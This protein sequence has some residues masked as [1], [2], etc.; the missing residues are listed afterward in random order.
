LNRSIS[1]FIPSFIGQLHQINIDEISNDAYVR[2]YFKHLCSHSKY[3]L[4]IYAD[5]LERAEKATQ[6][7]RSDIALLDYGAGLGLLGIFAAVAGFGAVSINEREVS[8][9]NAAEKISSFFQLK[10]IEFIAGEITPV[11]ETESWGKPDVLVAT[12]VIEH[13]YS[14]DEFLV[15]AKKINNRLIFIFTTGSN[16]ENYW[17]VKKLQKL[18]WR[19]EHLGHQPSYEQELGGYAHESFL[20]LRKKLIAQCAPHLSTDIVFSLARDTR[21]LKKDDLLNAIQRYEKDGLWP[22]VDVD[23][24]NTCHPETGSWT[25]KIV[26][27][28]QYHAIFD[29]QKYFIKFDPG[30]Y[31]VDKKGFKS[32]IAKMA[33]AFIFIFGMKIAPFIFLTAKISTSEISNE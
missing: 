28:K 13:L 29:K 3:Y 26:E 1:G 21:G 22:C 17:K 30:Y 20:N 18:Q 16:P 2:D 14:I 9:L 19:D 27:L 8:F 23:D 32:I 10:N 12:D 33:N 6:K 31:D 24:F 11:E 7:N 15:A 25:E 4:K 5:V